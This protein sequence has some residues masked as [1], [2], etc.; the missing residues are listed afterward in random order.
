MQVFLSG[1]GRSIT[2]LTGGYSSPGWGYSIPG[3]G[4]SS[5]GPGVPQSWPGD[6]PVQWK[7]L[8]PVTGVPTGR[9]LGPVTGVPPLGRD[10]GPLTGVPQEGTWD[11][12]LEVL[13]DGDVVPPGCELTKELKLLHS[14][15][16]CVG[17]VKKALL[18]SDCEEI[19]LSVCPSSAFRSP[20]VFLPVLLC[21]GPPILCSAASALLMFSSYN[22]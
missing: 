5:P 8:G 11:Q 13:W 17:A 18:N 1:R 2:V 12:W 21:L 4:Y 14:L 15:I 22:D 3:Q 16:L 6:T 19:T 10:R 7:D 9:D 20:S